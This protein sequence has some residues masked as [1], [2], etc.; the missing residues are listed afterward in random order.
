MILP[1][2]ETKILFRNLLKSIK[3]DMV[4]DIGSCDCSEAIKLALILPDSRVVAF[5]LDSNNFKKFI[6]GPCVFKHNMRVHNRAI[7]NK[8]EEVSLNNID[9][10]AVRNKSR[11]SLLDKPNFTSCKVMVRECRLDSFVNTNYQKI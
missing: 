2:L 5:E 9:S 3:P 7:T 6:R 11:S 4:F 8:D 1:E 10:E